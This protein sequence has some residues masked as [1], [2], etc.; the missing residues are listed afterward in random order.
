MGLENAVNVTNNAVGRLLAVDDNSDSAELIAR[1]AMRCGY[2]A[3]CLTDPRL[4]SQMLKDWQPEIVT[5]DLCMP[6]EDGIETLSQLRTG[7]FTGHLVIISG[8]DDSMR[9]VASRLAVA[10]GLKLAAHL[11]K[12]IDLPVLR[13][14][15]ATLRD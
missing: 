10:R 5:L 13:N 7:G 12:P 1:V 4:L 8:Q 3:R 14:L 11:S 15:L 9:D 2:E 6:Q